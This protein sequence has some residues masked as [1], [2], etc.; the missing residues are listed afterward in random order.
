MMRVFVD[1]NIFQEFIEHRL[2]FDEVQMILHAAENSEI[3][4]FLSA[5]TLYTL[6]FLS[7]KSLKH[8]DIHKPQLTELI[9][10]ILCHVLNIAKLVNLSHDEA[11]RAAQDPYFTDIEDSFQ[12]HCASENNCDVLLTINIKDFKDAK[13]KN[14]KVLTPLEF[15][16]AYPELFER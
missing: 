4:L 2:H 14:M 1:T 16:K 15:I 7:E 9:R 13:T 6:S 11:I 8:K 3:Q 10:T 12:F 5:G